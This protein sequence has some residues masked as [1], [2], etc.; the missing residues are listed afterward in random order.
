[1]QSDCESS[2]PRLVRK[3]LSV[4]GVKAER[5]RGWH[6]DGGGLYLQVTASGVK[7]WLFRYAIKGR[8]RA[9]GLGSVELVGLADAR[10]RALTLRRLL[11]DGI[12]P[13]EQR[14]ATK[15]EAAKAMTFAD[16][17][18]AYVD[19]HRPGWRGRRHAE[20]WQAS[21][22][23]HATALASLPV[24]A[25]DLVHVMK[26]LEPIWT[27]KPNTAARV[28]ARIERVLDWATVRKFRKGDNPVRWTGHLDH[29]LPAQSGPVR[30]HAALPYAEV[31]GFIA[32]LRERPEVSARAFE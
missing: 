24:Q 28:R 21:L 5:R 22:A 14:R 9:M 25:I 23:N 19:A 2:M 11:L 30:H 6:A 29:L 17:T 26:V 15:A 18:R 8:A 10:E 16:C 27:V 4:A 32:A 20:A 13:L 12:D 7:S 3:Q 1:M 31:A